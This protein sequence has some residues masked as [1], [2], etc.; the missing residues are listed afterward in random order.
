MTNRVLH[1]LTM[2]TLAILLGFGAVSFAA[3]PKEN[4]I[5]IDFRNVELTDLIQTISEMTGKNFIYDESVK[6]KV[7]I[8]SP[9]RMTPW[10]CGLS[11]AP[12]MTGIQEVSW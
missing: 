10:S 12:G 1:I 6:G 11:S 8:I 3:E 2:T 5:A 4:G 9:D 7:S